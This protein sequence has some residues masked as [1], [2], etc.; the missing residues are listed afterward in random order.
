[1]AQN[2]AAIVRVYSKSTRF[3]TAWRDACYTSTLNSTVMPTI[4]KSEFNMLVLSFRS[5]TLLFLIVICS[6]IFPVCAQAP[7]VNDVEDI[8][9]PLYNPFLERYMLD[10][11]K[12]LRQDQQAIKAEVAEKVASAKLEAS[13]RAIR[14]TADTTNNIFYIITI[15]A[16]LLV[17]LGWKSL[18]DIKNNV[19]S[20]TVRRVEELTAEYEN[21]LNNMELTLKQRSD[22]II[23]AQQDISENTLVHSLWM[24]SGLEIN[25]H[26]KLKIYDQ[27]LEVRPDDVEALTYKADTL[28]DI[29]E[30]SWALS[31]VEQA[32]AIDGDYAIAYWQKACAEAK[33]GLVNEALLDIKKALELSPALREE[34]SSESNFEKLKDLQEFKALIE[35]IISST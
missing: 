3:T 30:D 33:L 2:L 8:R 35:G 16:S 10:E 11:L 29:D 12:Q 9:E 34:L 13:D 31:L 19:K 18:N 17:L 27:I 14:Y 32:L 7:T 15:A 6:G 21:R 1:M 28:L 4:K 5:I 23:D 25:E 20:I 24:R 26:E 22:E